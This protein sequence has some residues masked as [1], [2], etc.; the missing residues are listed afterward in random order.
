MKNWVY[1]TAISLLLL[2]CSKEETSLQP[3]KLVEPIAMNVFCQNTPNDPLRSIEYEYSD[4]KLVMETT[5]QQGN[6]QSRITY[7]YNPDDQ[8]ILETYETN[9]QKIA[10]TFIY[11]ELD[12]LVS[13]KYNITKFDGNGLVTDESER[14]TALEYE[15]GLLVKESEYWGGFITYEYQ[16]GKVISRIDHTATGEKHHITT[17]KYSGDLLIEEK[18]E[19][20]TGGVIYLKTYEYD[21]RNRLLAIHDRG[22]TIEENE[23]LNYKLIEKR[24]YYFGI[25]PGFDVCYGNYIYRYEY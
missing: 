4:G 13:I 15:N 8:L 25:D 20:S 17:Y 3:A 22:N 16:F 14:E 1:L 24:T 5:T 23:Y 18:K 10:K 2:S 6:V 9:F 11:N 12:Q 21:F 19:N 7:D